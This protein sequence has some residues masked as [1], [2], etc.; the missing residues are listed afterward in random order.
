MV[1]VDDRGYV[2]CCYH[3]HSLTSP[4]RDDAGRAHLCRGDQF[5]VR[6]GDAYVLYQ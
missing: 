3:L 2:L 5:H 6:A 1:F 4:G